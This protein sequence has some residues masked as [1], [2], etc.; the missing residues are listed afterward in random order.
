MALFRDIPQY[1]RSAAYTVS[2]PWDY[3]ENWLERQSSKC[4]MANTLD[5]DPDFQRAHVWDDSKRVRYVEHVLRGGRGALNLYFNH[6]NWMGSFK[7]VLELV[8]GKQR[9]ES[10]RKFLNNELP[11]FGRLLEDYDDRLPSSAEFFVNVNSLKTRREVLQWYID[12]NDGGVA[13]T[14]EEIEKVRNLLLIE[15]S[16]TF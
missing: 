4:G 10:V 15:E 7:G 9:L 16:S 13:H 2:I 14:P 12:L 6:P 1:T 3:L 11:A 5:L 8:D